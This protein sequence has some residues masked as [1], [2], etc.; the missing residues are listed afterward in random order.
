[1]RGVT[2]DR[3]IAAP[4]LRLEINRDA[5]SRLGVATQA[6]DDTLY[7]AVP[8][9]QSD[10]IIACP[11]GK[12][13]GSAGRLAT[14][15]GKDR[16]VRLWDKE[17]TPL[18]TFVIPTVSGG[19]QW[20]PDGQV[21]ATLDQYGLVTLW[22]DNRLLKTFTA[23]RKIAVNDAA[24][25]PDGQLLASASNNGINLWRQDYDQGSETEICEIA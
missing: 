11:D 5:A 25:S 2:T 21:L 3:Q 12:T 22:K 4:T 17:G 9:Q 15:S 8:R 14:A 18:D 16:T 1:L 13:E 6:I 24:L 10:S 19:V 23:P 7:D 20:R